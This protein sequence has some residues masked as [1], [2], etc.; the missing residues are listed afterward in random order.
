M[1]IR[2][3][4]AFFIKNFRLFHI[5]FLFLSFILLLNTISLYEF[6]HKYISN[7]AVILTS[8]EVSSVLVNY[9]WIFFLLIGLCIVTGVLIYKKKTVK[10]YIIQIL[11][12]TSLLFLFLFCNNTLQELIRYL[13]DIRLIKALHDILFV[14]CIMQSIS[15]VLLFTR[16][17]SFDIKKFDFDKEYNLLVADES[18]REE[19]EVAFDL[20]I[21]TLKTKF[22]KISRNLKYFYLENKLISLILMGLFSF[23]FI[24][25]IILYIKTTSYTNINGNVINKGVYKLEYKGFYL[26]DSDISNN[27]ID[28]NSLFIIVDVDIKT[29]SS[30]PFPTANLMLSVDNNVYVPNSSYNQYFEDFGAGYKTHEIKKEGRYYFVYRVPSYTTLEEVKLVYY[31]NDK[32]YLK[33]VNYI[34]LTKDI[35]N[36]SFGIG[37]K[38]KINSSVIGTSDFVINEVSFKERFLVPYIYKIGN[39]NYKSSFYVSPS[40][41]GNFDKSVIRIDSNNCDLINDYGKIYYGNNNDLNEAKVSLKQIKNIK[42]SYDFCY[43][44]T[45]KEVIDSSDVLLKI[46]I[47]G[48]IYN[49]YLK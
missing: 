6:F 42:K 41:S 5:L 45:D 4:Y 2:K 15:V 13:V 12:Y 30:K 44:E 21:N 23:I 8:F 25:G 39:T 17:A 28:D 24:I 46:N 20:D 43:Y 14:F 36:G 16:A 49:Y 33:N 38:V 32:Y 40:I 11:I 29:S 47:R 37:D 7:G 48:N 22:N 35:N 26:D 34:D 9:F 1:I 3:P 31:N 19:V 10:F 27:I 18:D